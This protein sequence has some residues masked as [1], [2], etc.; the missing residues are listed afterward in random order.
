[1]ML[2]LCMLI[3]QDIDRQSYANCKLWKR[4]YVNFQYFTRITIIRV[5]ILLQIVLEV[6]FGINKLELAMTSLE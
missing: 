2:F 6:N 1:M 4:M 3:V 5:I